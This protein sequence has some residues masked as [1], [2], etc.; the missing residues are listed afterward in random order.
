MHTLSDI[1]AILENFAPLELAAAWDNVGLLVGNRTKPVH[2]VMT[3]LT[4]TDASVSE[5]V[6]Q[7]A[8]LVV[9]HHPLPFQPLKRITSDTREGR[10]LLQLIAANIAVYSPHT[11]FDSSRAGINQHL[12]TA[13]RLLDI[14][15]L[16]VADG[17]DD[18]LGTGR[19]GILPG[20]QTLREVIDRLKT[21]LSLG[22]V[23]GV[24]QHDQPIE[25]IAIACGSGGS[26]LDSAIAAGCHA[27]ITGEA[28]FHTCLAAEA[29]GIAILLTGHYASE[30]FALD[31]LA[32]YLG[33]QLPEIEA[34]ASHDEHDPLWIA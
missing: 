18:E 8:D 9:T 27:F 11:A 3:C 12:A 25:R 20:P 28:D 26:L 5:A 6:E 32:E 19:I 16:V 29:A 31:A 14:A 33:E 17:Q 1:I 23:R 2:R 15:P 10:M 7:G 24:G 34:W 30:R 22:I 4:M 13:L 21:A